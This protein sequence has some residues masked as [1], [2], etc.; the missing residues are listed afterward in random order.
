MD[1]GSHGRIDEG[2]QIGSTAD[3]IENQSTAINVA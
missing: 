2:I 3:E 1:E